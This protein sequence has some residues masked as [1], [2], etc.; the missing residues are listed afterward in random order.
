M[1]YVDRLI[2]AFTG[3]LQES[4]RLLAQSITWTGT[5]VFSGTVTNSGTQNFTGSVSFTGTTTGGG[6]II[7][8]TSATGMTSFKYTLMASRDAGKTIVFTSGGAASRHKRVI[9]PL[10]STMTGGA[11]GTIYRII[12]GQIAHSSNGITIVT[13][14]AS[15]RQLNR[16]S[17]PIKSTSR[18]L[19]GG[20]ITLLK[21]NNRWYILNRD[22]GILASTNARNSLAW[23]QV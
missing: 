22:Y 20:G 3:G 2:Q 14:A 18:I 21:A 19:T 15:G 10:A 23:L 17:R 4:A 6:V 11:S 1:G 12:S 16:S 9:L 7:G 13:S 8:P 5:H